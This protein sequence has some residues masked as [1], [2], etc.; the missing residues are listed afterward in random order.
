MLVFF[1]TGAALLEGPQPFAARILTSRPVF[2]WSLAAGA[3][4]IFLGRLLHLVFQAFPD[5]QPT[6]GTQPA[7]PAL[8]AASSETAASTPAAEPTARLQPIAED[9]GTEDASAEDTSGGA[10]RPADVP[11]ESGQL[12]HLPVPA[13]TQPGATGADAEPAAPAEPAATAQPAAPTPAA[14]PTARLQPT[15]EGTQHGSCEHR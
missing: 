13:G 6:P 10:V 4:C 7:E 9:A 14:E 11:T 15:V 1:F 8:P 12:L 3:L 5:E 2:W